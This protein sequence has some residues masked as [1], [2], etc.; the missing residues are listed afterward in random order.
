[1]NIPEPVTIKNLSILTPVFTSKPLFGDICAIVEPDLIRYI[2]PIESACILNNPLP[3]PL[4][5]EADIKDEIFTEPV[6]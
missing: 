3:S 2:S 5:K 1:L 6:N 4:N